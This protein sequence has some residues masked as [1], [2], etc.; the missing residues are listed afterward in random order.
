[1]RFVARPADR[2]SIKLETASRSCTREHGQL[3]RRGSVASEHKD[4]GAHAF[5]RSSGLNATREVGRGVPDDLARSRD[6]DAAVAA[7]DP[8]VERTAAD[9]AFAPDA[10]NK[11]RFLHGTHD[12]VWN[13]A[14]MQVDGMAGG[15]C[16]RSCL[17]HRGRSAVRGPAADE[18]ASCGEHSDKLLCAPSVHR[19]TIGGT[20]RFLKAT[21]DGPMPDRRRPAF[22]CG[23][24]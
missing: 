23:L 2:V 6:R 13:V 19:C 1:M 5:K 22:Q 12:G 8:R 14:G 3:V 24:L 16:G 15:E 11:P 4:N 9:R 18:N 7:F 17:W 10:D 20:V 21:H